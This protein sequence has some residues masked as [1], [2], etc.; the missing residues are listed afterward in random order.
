[1]L[2]NQA[3]IELCLHVLAYDVDEYLNIAIFPD[4]GKY[5]SS[6]AFEV[7]LETSSTLPRNVEYCIMALFGWL[8]PYSKLG[9][10]VGSTSRLSISSSHDIRVEATLDTRSMY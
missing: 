6:T 8:F 5:R 9:L 7:A 2:L 10:G 3:A 4:Q 1:V